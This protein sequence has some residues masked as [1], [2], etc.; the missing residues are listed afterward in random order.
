M[1]ATHIHD[2]LNTDLGC[3]CFPTGH[4][5]NAA[6]NLAME[7]PREFWIG[8]QYVYG[9]QEAA[10]VLPG[11]NQTIRQPLPDLVNFEVMRHEGNNWGY[12]RQG[13][14]DETVTTGLQVRTS[15][16]LHTLI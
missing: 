6:L 12:T 14:D 16:C 3:A 2:L 9:R 15:S 1:V 10:H 13:I 8:D 5:L 7:S 4:M 11:R